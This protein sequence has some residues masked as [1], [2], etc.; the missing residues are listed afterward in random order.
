MVALDELLLTG[1]FNVTL[2]ELFSVLTCPLKL[3]LTF[4]ECFFD[5]L[6]T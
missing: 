2:Y 3:S 5:G 6:D 4:P 1:D